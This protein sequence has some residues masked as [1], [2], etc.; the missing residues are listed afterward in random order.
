MGWNPEVSDRIVGFYFSI[1]MV[2]NEGLLGR[3]AW[4]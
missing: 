3:R 2:V 1:F 4:D